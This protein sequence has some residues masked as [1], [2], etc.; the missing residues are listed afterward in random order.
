MSRN[1]RLRPLS[2]SDNHT[3][4][5]SNLIDRRDFLRYSFN[6]AAGGITMACLGSIGFAS[7]LMGQADASGGDSAVRFWVP[8][9]AEDTVWY[10]DSHLQPM[11]YDAFVQA[12]ANSNTG[13]TG[14]QGVWSGMPVNVIYVP[15][16]ENKNTATA[17]NKPRFQYTDGYNS[18]G[19]YV[20]SGYEIYEKPEYAAL[21]IHDN[22]IIVF[23][24]C[25]HLCC[26]PGWQLV[27]NDYTNDS[28]EAGGTESGGNKLFC[29]CHSSRFDPTAI[30]KN[31]MGRGTPFQYIGIKRVGGPA[32][33]GMPLVPFVLNG[34][35]IEALPDFVDWYAYCS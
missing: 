14:A 4:E 16:A 15:D 35:M 32:P 12:S 34:D 28:W 7:L 17:A 3:E 10:G 11:S 21:S 30:E 8:T 5:K 23:S 22:L 26:I 9:G 2:D 20:G 29:I 13:M 25:P 1:F 19:K 31:S 33:N 24:R 27:T 18:G 6:T